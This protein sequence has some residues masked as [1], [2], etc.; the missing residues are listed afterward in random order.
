MP[1]PTN[2][3]AENRLVMTVA[4]QYDICPQGSTYPMK[5]VAIMISRM[6]TPKIHSSS[7]GALYDP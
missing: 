3:K 4:P 5:A 2:G 1:C 7:R 6:I